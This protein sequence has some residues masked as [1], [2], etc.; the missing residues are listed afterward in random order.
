MVVEL[1]WASLRRWLWAPALAAWCGLAHSYEIRA[2]GAYA[3]DSTCTH[4]TM[5]QAAEACVNSSAC[6]VRPDCDEAPYG[7]FGRGVRWNDD[8]LKLLDY[9]SR[10][11]AFVGYLMHAKRIAKAR[12]AKIDA[13]YN[14]LYRSHFGDL[15]FLHAMARVEGEPAAETQARM[16][17][18]AEFTYQVW[19]GEIDLQTELSQVSVR[20]VPEL[21]PGKRWTVR[22]LFSMNCD[23]PTSGCREPGADYTDELIRQTALGSLLHM[24]QDS[25][26]AGHTERLGPT[27]EP[28]AEGL[29]VD[30]GSI[31]RFHSYAKQDERLHKLSDARPGWAKSALAFQGR[32]PVSDSARLLQLAGLGANK[33]SA[34]WMKVRD[35]LVHWAFEIEDPRSAA[36]SQVTG[37]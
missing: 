10:Y 36:D 11:P 34:D 30:F 16:L 35:F 18:W 33:A 1:D 13:T 24:I 14:S 19:L 4:E 15:Q 28:R 5:T 6:S 26:S 3:Y 29:V 22:R 21:F 20:G 12:P 32:N 31:K 2:S 8:P 37:T 27:L 23:T 7:K 25:Y 9:G 17:L